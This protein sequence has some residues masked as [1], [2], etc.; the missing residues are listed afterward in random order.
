MFFILFSGLVFSLSLTLI[1]AL[2][3]PSDARVAGKIGIYSNGKSGEFNHLY[4][5]LS[6]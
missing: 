4:F 1:A 6:P 5:L 3:A 2:V